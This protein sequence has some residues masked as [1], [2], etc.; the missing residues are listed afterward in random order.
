[1]R[2]R[3]NDRAQGQHRRPAAERSEGRRAG[4]GAESR[5]TGDGAT[6]PQQPALG[7]YFGVTSDVQLLEEQARLQAEADEVLEDLDLVVTLATV[8]VPHSVGSR[9]LG[10]MVR[11]DV[12]LTVAC[13][14]LDLRAL[15]RLGESVALHPRVR[16][17][18]FRDD[19]GVWNVDGRYPDGVYWG[20][21]YVRAG[22][23]SWNVD[24]WFVDQPER[25]PDLR[26]VREL[27]PL[28]EDDGA[29]R[30]ILSIKHALNDD[31]RYGTRLCGR[32]IYLAV[33]HHGVTSLNDIEAYLATR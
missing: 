3:A 26:D 12:D 25:Q 22:G 29:R 13:D 5:A 31:P 9:A 33:L 27:L 19:T 7:Q 8:G 2:K 14:R 18:R 1:V 17:L 6:E 10:V 16:V 28:L 23:V 15:Y 11:R 4:G 21:E 32:D 24:V 30:R 20:I